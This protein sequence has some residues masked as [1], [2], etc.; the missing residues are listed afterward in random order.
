MNLP[1]LQYITDNPALAEAACR[2]GVRWV[3][4]RIKEKST[5][6]TRR[7]AGEILR[8]CRKY[9]SLCI[10]NDFP[11]IALALSADGVH[12]GRE[13]LAMNE[14]LELIGPG[15]FIAGGTAN[16]F[17]DVV[18]LA[19]LKVSYIGLGPFRFTPTKKKLSPVLGPEG[20]SEILHRLNMEKISIPPVFAI[21]GVLPADTKALMRAGVYGVAVSGIISA[22]AD[23]K[24]II[25]KFNWILNANK[26]SLAGDK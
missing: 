3:Q 20:Y 2:A 17:E 12:L 6:D 23:K 21:G 16:T 26:T 4:A 10:I 15:K 1:R 24:E 5:D 9:N 7:I 19:A 8:V 11:E 25:E 22:S 14:A 13:D 18:S